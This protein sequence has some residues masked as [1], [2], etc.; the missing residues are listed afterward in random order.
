[1]GIISIQQQILP[2]KL[3]VKRITNSKFDLKKSNML[4]PFALEWFISVR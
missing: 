4:A 3:N 2:T 1:M